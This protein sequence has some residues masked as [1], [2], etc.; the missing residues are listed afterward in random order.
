MN[1]NSK[2]WQDKEWRAGY[3]AACLYEALPKICSA[4][5]RDGYNQAQHD[6]AKD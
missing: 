4:A 6:L 5:F 2:Y 1:L 3:D